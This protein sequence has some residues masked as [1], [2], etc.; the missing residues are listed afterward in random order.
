MFTSG[1]AHVESESQQTR[2]VSVVDLEGV[3]GVYLNP[4]LEPPF[5][6]KIF[7]FHGEF[8]EKSG[9]IDK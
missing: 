9:N 1:F 4:P 2:Q 5:E 3:G 6:T 8:S 7:N